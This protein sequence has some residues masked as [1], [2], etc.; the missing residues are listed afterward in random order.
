MTDATA[1]VQSQAD[2]LIRE[3]V[4]ARGTPEACYALAVLLN[5]TVTELHKVAR[6]RVNETRGQA[7]WGQWAGLQNTART[8]VL[9]SSTA[10]DAAAK[11]VGRAR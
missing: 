8:L 10:R 1:D 5:R 4:G 6:A 2:A 11:L 3:F 7:E 9:Q